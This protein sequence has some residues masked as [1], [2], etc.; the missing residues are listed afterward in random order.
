MAK[1]KYTGT[2]LVTKDGTQEDTNKAALDLLKK[3]N[4]VSSSS[5]QIN[6]G[7]M[8]T[9]A[10]VAGSS[11]GFK[12]DL[13]IFYV[14]SDLLKIV[15]GVIEINGD[16][17]DISSEIS[18]PSSMANFPAAG[19][20]AYV[21][22]KKDK[23]AE[24]FPAAGAANVRPSDNCYQLSGGGVG[25][26]DI[27]KCHYMY[28]PLRVIVGAIHKVNATTWYIINNGSGLSEKGA[29]SLGKWERTENRG[30]KIQTGG[31]SAAPVASVNFPVQFADTPQYSLSAFGT[32][33]RHVSMTAISASAYTPA[34]WNAAEILVATQYSA[35]FEGSF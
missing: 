4:E 24:L 31:T 19:A 13:N 33:T 5:D 23:T 7:L 35:L 1:D 11:K 26:S 17:I 15:P 29:N 3:I 25:Y 30:Q 9:N 27:K 34:L 14:S 10:L 32:V 18:I 28:D 6:T 22:M 12:R 8:V 16:I 21:T 20:W 2:I